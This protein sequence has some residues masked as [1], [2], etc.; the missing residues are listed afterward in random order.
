MNA[1]SL[2][3]LPGL[4]LAGLK[5]RAVALAGKG[6]PALVLGGWLAWQLCSMGLVYWIAGFCSHP[7]AGLAY[8]IYHWDERPLPMSFVECLLHVGWMA[9][10]TLGFILL[11]AGALGAKAG[12]PAAKRAGQRAEVRAQA[13]FE[14][15]RSGFEALREAASLGAELPPGPAGPRASR[16]L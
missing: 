3:A 14:E 15:R 13:G 5:W 6:T 12:F 7:V 2:R 11:A 8:G 4:A 1:S 10:I 16:R 9:D